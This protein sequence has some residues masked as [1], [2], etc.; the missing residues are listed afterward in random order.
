MSRAFEFLR[1][2]LFI[3]Y[4]HQARFEKITHLL[5]R[6][7]PNTGRNQ[8]AQDFSA[9]LFQFHAALLAQCRLGLF[10]VTVSERTGVTE[11]SHGSINLRFEI[12][13]SNSFLLTKLSSKLLRLL[14]VDQQ[15]SPIRTNNAFLYPSSLLS[16]GLSPHRGII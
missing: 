12:C 10:Y 7:D 4:C 9:L 3:Y 11:I 2:A 16:L 1:K 13:S 14:A 6:R 5:E 15:Q 8:Q